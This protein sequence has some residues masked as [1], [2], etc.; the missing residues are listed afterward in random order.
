MALSRIKTWIAEVLYYADLNAE[1][2]N[3]LNNGAGSLSSPRTANFDL[4]GY[5]IILD[6]DADTY[7]IATSDDVLDFYGQST[8]LVR[9]DL[10]VAS[11]TNGLGITAAATGVGPDIVTRGGDTN[12][13]LRIQPKGTGKVVIDGG[14]AFAAAGG[15]ADAITAT[16]SPVV[17]AL[18]D[19]LHL[20]VVAASANATTTPT[21]APNGLTAKTIVKGANAALIAGDIA[22]A[23]H[24]LELTYYQSADKWVL[25]NP[26]ATGGA[27]D[28][29]ALATDTTGGATDDLIPFVDTSDA[30][31]SNK[32]TTQSLI[33]NLWNNFAQDTA[34]DHTNDFLVSRDVSA[35][36]PKKVALKH[37]GIGKQTCWIPASAMTARTTN[38][39]ATGTTEST[40]NKVM[41]KVLD[42]DQTTQE[43]A[44]FTVAFPKGWN[45]GTVTFIPYWTAASSS[46]GVVWGLAGVAVSDDDVIDAAFGTAQTSTDT[47]IATTDVHVGPESAAITIGG[48]PAEGDIVYFQIA[49]NP[50]DGSD[51]LAADARLIGIKLLYTIDSNI[52]D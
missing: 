21:F 22:G 32:V 29:N 4:D 40:T 23:G 19:G 8:A 3:V 41:N 24:I 47:L 2:D 50:S 31:A 30:N 11:P 33:Y 42:Y 10:S 28:L 36:A 5:Q 17:T 48:T 20:Y 45:E 39:A 25:L 44:Q 52:D 16:F 37:V 38:G 34:P 12:I 51:T 18:D 43:F 46:G 15:S 9:L 7:L 6:A 35:T 14:F 26:T 13:G 27:V 1:F 49:R